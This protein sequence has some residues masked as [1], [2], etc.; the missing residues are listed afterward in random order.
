LG[1]VAAESGGEGHRFSRVL[2]VRSHRRENH[3][4]G[5]PQATATDSTAP[6]SAGHYQNACCREMPVADPSVR[7]VVRNLLVLA[8]NIVVVVLVFLIFRVWPDWH[9]AAALPGFAFLGVDGIAVCLL[10]GAI[11]AR[12]R[13]VAPIVGSVMQIAYFITPIIWKPQLVGRNAVWL[14]LN[15]SSRC[16]RS[17]DSRCLAACLRR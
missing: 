12:F 5:L 17:C 14:P 2:R 7:T 16:W 3:A 11:C 8:H 6:S 4:K 13:D 9:A 1:R 15:P 10:F